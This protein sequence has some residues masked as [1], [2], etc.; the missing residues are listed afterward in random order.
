M[1]F[2]SKVKG[3][4]SGNSQPKGAATG[5]LSD[6]ILSGSAPRR[7]TRE[8]LQAYRTN[9]WWHAATHKVCGGVA[10]VPLEVW[11]TTRRKSTNKRM[12][13]HRAATKAA[14]SY[15]PEGGTKLTAHEL[16]DLLDDP[17]PAFTR[18]VF[19]YLVQAYIDTKGYAV[20]VIERDKAGKPLEL[21]PV[22]PHWV[23]E[24]PHRNFPSYRFSFGTWQRT[25]SEDDVLVIRHPD[26]EQPYVLGTGY[27][28][29]LADELD[30]DEFASK[31]LKD[32]FFNKA[33]PDAFLSVDGLTGEDEA[34]R[35]EEKLRQKNG[36]RGKGYQ[37]HV[38]SGKVDVKELSH[39]FREQMLPELRTGS[40]D[41]VLQV[42]GVPPEIMGIVEDSNRATIDGAVVIFTRF[43]ITPR[44]SFL[45]DAFTKWARIEWEDD[46]LC[47]GYVS[48]IPSDQTFQLSVMSAQP[49]LFTKNEWRELAGQEARPGWDDEFPE[50]RAPMMGAGA[51]GLPAGDDVEDEEDPYAVEEDEETKSARR[52]LRAVKPLVALP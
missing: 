22:P 18:A 19:F 36:L 5:L 30:I 42:I 37:L 4:F 9:P 43:T 25:I 45:A 2:F 51:P 10:E 23:A 49:T 20:L 13:S 16:L 47:V 32:W 3:L 1:G 39:T 17:C 26:L 6:T 34:V 50:E 35:Y 33:L 8:L 11:K 52:F 27:G 24:T 44:L 29:S 12:E 38:T 14:I 15:A 48:P 46:T 31:H 7:G 41:M 40:R 21:W 28:E